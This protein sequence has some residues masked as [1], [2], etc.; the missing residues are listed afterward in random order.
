MRRLAREAMLKIL[1]QREYHGDLDIKQSLQLLNTTSK[2]PPQAQKYAHSMGTHLLEA[3]SIID[4]RIQAVSPQWN[5]NRMTLVDLS[6]LRLACF[7]ITEY[8]HEVP[9]KVAI[10][11]AVELAK[12][13]GS[14]DSPG[15]I[16]GLL[17]EILKKHS[18]HTPPS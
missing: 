17:N 10:N 1:F 4:E 16:N 7:E 6:I 2:I 13:Y 9:A 5:L 14:K 11:E 8:S 15:F 3:Q 18:S 12:K